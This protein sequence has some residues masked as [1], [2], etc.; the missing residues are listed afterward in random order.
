MIFD[1]GRTEK[2]R[3]NETCPSAALCTANP[4]WTD[5]MDWH[6]T[7]QDYAM[8]RGLKRMGLHGGK[9]WGDRD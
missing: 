2:Y 5:P 4:T 3:V 6:S 8:G 9:E 1:G 7:G